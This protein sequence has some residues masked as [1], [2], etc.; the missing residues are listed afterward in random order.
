MLL[1]CTMIFASG[2]FTVVFTSRLALTSS[3]SPVP[4]APE[5]E[6]NVLPPIKVHPPENSLLL[7]LI[8]SV[9]SSSIVVG[10]AVML[11]S[12]VPEISEFRMSELKVPVTSMALSWRMDNAPSR[13]RDPSSPVNKRDPP[14]RRRSSILRV[15]VMSLSIRSCAPAPRISSESPAKLTC[16][17]EGTPNEDAMKSV[18]R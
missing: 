17:F 10:E 5:P 13:V 1:P 9:S 7:P 4:K 6:A 18:T 15:S 16:G 12:P 14:D 2:L 8:I 11:S 3:R